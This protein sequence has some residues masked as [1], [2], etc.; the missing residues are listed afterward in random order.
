MTTQRDGLDERLSE[1]GWTRHYF[2]SQTGMS[3]SALVGWKKRKRY[4]AWADAYLDL[5]QRL[6]GIV[7]LASPGMVQ[8]KGAAR[9]VP[10]HEQGDREVDPYG[11]SGGTQQTVDGPEYRKKLD[12][13]EESDMDQSEGWGE[14]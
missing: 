10:I 1:L 5:A 6:R 3:H 8:P 11:L 13:W 2:A 9:G 12:G 14:G 4:P 7:D